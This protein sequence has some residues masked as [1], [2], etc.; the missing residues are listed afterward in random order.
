MKSGMTKSH[1]WALQRLVQVAGSI[2]VLAD[3]D[4]S[5]EISGKPGIAIEVVVDDRLFNPG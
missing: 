1:A 2:E 4:G 3:L 5:F